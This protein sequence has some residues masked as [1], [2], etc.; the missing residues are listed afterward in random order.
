MAGAWLG[1]V[2]PLML[3]AVLRSD[4]WRR[5]GVAL[6]LTLSTVV[7]VLLTQSRNAMGALALA[8]PFVLGPMQWFWLSLIHI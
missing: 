8:I 4:G 3:A 2:W 6:L 5:R 7:A 1:V